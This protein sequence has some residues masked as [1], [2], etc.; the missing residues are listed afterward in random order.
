MLLANNYCILLRSRYAMQYGRTVLL[1]G[2]SRFVMMSFIRL[3]ANT[4]ATILEKKPD[5]R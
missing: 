5:N 2:Y 1:A 3:I 4:S